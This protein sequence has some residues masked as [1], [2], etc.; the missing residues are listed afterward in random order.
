MP[1]PSFNRAS[2]DRLLASCPCRIGVYLEDL[3]SGASY[4]HRADDL[5][6]TASICK[7]PVMIALYQQAHEGRVSLDER[8]RLGDD[9]AIWGSGT[10]SLLRDGPEMTLRDYCRFMIGISD[11]M[12]T[13]LLM[14]RVGFDAI[15]TLMDAFGCPRTRVNMTMGQWHDLV[16][17]M[18]GV[19]C[20]HAHY[21]E[22]LRSYREGR[23]NWNTVASQASLD[24]NITTP[25]EIGALLSAIHR[26]E[27]VSPAASAEM[28]EI[29]HGC[30]DRNMIPRDLVWHVKVAHKVGSG[31][32]VKAD[33]G[34]VYLP[35]GPLL[36]SVMLFDKGGAAQWIG[37]VARLAVE[38][39]SP[40]SING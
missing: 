21:P 23:R 1:K 39:L 9:I 11:N 24:N 17:D 28:L 32:G 27:A 35:T 15:N 37:D 36:A 33:A 22:L 10:L 18:G 40:E 6:P 2:F 12:A 31:C 34:V 14:R 7:V 26:G 19:P 30:T 4:E 29:L 25:R 13:D 38:T 20:N 8:V 16:C 5:F 3:D